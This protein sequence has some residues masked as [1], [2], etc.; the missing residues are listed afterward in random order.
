MIDRYILKD[1]SNVTLELVSL[2]G[3]RIS[4]LQA[5]TQQPGSYSVSLGAE[6]NE[7]PS[8]IYF[9]RLTTDDKTSV[10]KLVRQSQ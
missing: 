4:V 7:C 1:K 2:T 5:R 8:G 6:S 3:E 10:S 9:V